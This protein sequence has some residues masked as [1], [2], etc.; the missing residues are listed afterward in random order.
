MGAL[1]ADPGRQ[2]DVIVAPA[3][4]PGVS[5]LAVI[6]LSG[7]AGATLAVA[8]RLAPRLP[9]APRA[10][11]ARLCRLVD[12][13]G[14]EVDDAVVLYYEAPRSST[15]EE[16][17]EL[18]CHGSPAIVAAL[19][20]AARE[21]GARPARPGEFTRRALAHG[22]LDLAAAEGI[23]LLAAAES[24]GAARRSLGLVDGAL[25]RRVRALREKLLDVLAGL[26]A[27]LDFEDDTPA[28]QAARSGAALEEAATGLDALAALARGGAADRLPSAVIAG[29]PNAGKSTLFNALV[30]SDRAIVTPVPGT[31]RDAISE[32]VEIGEERVR[33]LDTAGLRSGGDAVEAIGVTVAVRAAAEADLVLLVVDGSRA[34]D[35]ED[36]T[37]VRELDRGRGLVVRTKGDLP[38][39]P[40]AAALGADVAVSAATGAGLPALRRAMAGRL[41]AVESG[42]DLL[43]LERHREALSRAA[44]G[45]REAAGLLLAGEPPEL[46]AQSVR[47]ALLAVGEITGETATEELLDR[48]FATFCIGK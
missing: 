35:A 2:G 39:V 44:E 41:G 6:R 45:A 28:I 42:G 30:G 48:I 32:T 26:E 25:S 5:A 38:L 21:A 16:V 15:G 19:L 13:R 20:A 14:R 27:S 47:R 9:A 24:R 17:V 8:R 29:R 40:E 4:P 43:V 31:T 12:G 10:R 33:L 7:P 22:K 34:P 18:F 1:V 11:S 3:T 37:L 46:A 23:V 36:L